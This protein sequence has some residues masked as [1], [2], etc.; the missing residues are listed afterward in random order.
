MIRDRDR[1][2]SVRLTES[3]FCTRLW[4]CPVVLSRSSSMTASVVGSS[5]NPSNQDVRIWLAITRR[6][7]CGERAYS[8]SHRPKISTFFPFPPQIVM[9]VPPRHCCWTCPN[10]LCNVGE[11]SS[12]VAERSKIDILGKED[13]SLITA[14]GSPSGGCFIFAIYIH[15]TGRC[16]RS[17]RA[18]SA[19][20]VR[21]IGRASS[22]GFQREKLTASET[23][24][25]G[26]AQ[27]AASATAFA[28]GQHHI[29]EP[30]ALPP[31][32]HR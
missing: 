24:S 7:T 16:R 22:V 6:I 4:F 8:A 2:G 1:G 11:A 21:E 26:E 9:S 5:A 31:V 10:G 32:S 25:R 3:S 17:V 12:D 18:A 23:G 30:N 29:V 27:W 14:I 13:P 20:P 19:F 28:P 15:Y